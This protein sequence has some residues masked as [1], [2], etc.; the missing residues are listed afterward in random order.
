[1]QFELDQALARGDL[2]SARNLSATL[3]AREPNNAG[4]WRLRALIE[5]HLGLPE[6]ALAFLRQAVSLKP[7]E[8]DL[9]AEYA[10]VLELQGDSA[11][12]QSQLHEA[13]K[14]EPGVMRHKLKLAAVLLS[15]GKAS[16]AA[17][18]ARQVVTRQPSDQAGWH[19]LAD[20]ALVSGDWPA[21]LRSF[22]RAIE[23][24]A[25]EQRGEL[26]KL[27]YNVG[28]C[29]LK[30]RHPEQA[31]RAFDQALALDAKLYT[32][33]AQ[34]V[35]CQRRLAYW[36]DLALHS[37]RLLALAELGV[38]G[39]TPFSF[40]A[41][42]ASA[43]IQL[44]VARTEAK[45]ISRQ[46]SLQPLEAAQAKT[47]L[48]K[49]AKKLAQRTGPIR[50]GF[51]SNG[52][53]QHPTGLL[54]VEF[55][56]HIDRSRLHVVL[57]CTAPADHGEIYKRLAHASE[58]VCDL[59]FL[60]PAQAAQKVRELGMDVLFDLRGFGDG[61]VPQLF[62]LRPA[63]LQVNWLAYPGTS[64]APWLDY[65]FA[66]RTVLPPALRA[67]FSE[68]VVHLPSCFQPFDSRAKIGALQPRS[69]YGLPEN[70]VVLA[71]LNNSYKIN[72]QVFA[73]WME[74][75]HACPDAVLW[76]LKDADGEGFGQNLRAHAQRAGVHPDRLI[77]FPK[78]AHA[79]YLA[80][81][82]HAEL[83]LDTFPYGA[84]TT[85]R[86]ALFVGTPILTLTGETFAARVACSLNA[87][88]QMHALNA[89][90]LRTYIS[91]AIALT[92]SPEARVQWREHLREHRH[93]LFDSASF[94]H[95]FCTAVESIV[96]RA[97]LGLAPEDIS[98]LDSSLTSKR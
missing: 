43:T 88:V 27:W 5:V 23:L 12:A 33:L 66:D 3:S 58:H 1:M 82:Q 8:A 73:A 92:R 71:S 49:D 61:G 7:H 97:K 37:A 30:M 67:G 87:A 90:D 28:L 95:N 81:L 80:A 40:L 56:E 93:L 4:L 94:A 2:E 46:L 79:D 84:H 74:I 41:E 11:E 24:C 72:P 15:C 59:S 64:G 39:I 83:F 18:L 54:T 96:A 85:A 57:F 68:A 36:D 70:A 75:L 50:V 77:F 65:I 89:P 60:A 31:L 38:P 55:F 21:A 34:R 91:G 45:V 19:V 25:P 86:D 62:A 42:F 53:G 13:I 44:Q 22:Q 78:C 52:F 47:Q 32:A 98:L 20:C 51:V 9:R 63:P 6:H 29:A 17:M 10:A 76:L 69:A 48:R 26:A 35:F 14:L 16:E